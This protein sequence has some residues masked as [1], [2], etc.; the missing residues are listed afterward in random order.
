MHCANSLILL[1]HQLCIIATHGFREL[2]S[3]DIHASAG[4]K[5]VLTASFLIPSFNYGKIWIGW[6]DQ[7]HV[8]V[9]DTFYLL[10]CNAEGSACGMHRSL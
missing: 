4:T 5:I 6:G 9:L 3:A 7:P 10:K 2:L 8:S 1:S